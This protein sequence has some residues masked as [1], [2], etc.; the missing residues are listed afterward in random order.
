MAAIDIQTPGCDRTL[1]LIK[2]MI[3]VARDGAR[4]CLKHAPIAV[5][6][7]QFEVRLQKPSLETHHLYGAHGPGPHRLRQ[8]G[9]NCRT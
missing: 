5:A 2:G 9:S 4:N 7:I 3:L 8:D 6:A 1:S